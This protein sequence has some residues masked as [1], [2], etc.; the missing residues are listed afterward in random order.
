MPQTENEPR[1]RPVLVWAIFAV[2]CVLLLAGI[3]Y[4]LAIFGLVTADP[5]TAEKLP[6][7]RWTQHVAT[8]L[9]TT[10]CFLGAYRLFARRGGAMGLYIAGIA[11]YVFSNLVTYARGC[12]YYGCPSLEF[13]RGML[14]NLLCFVVAIFFIW[15]A[16]KS[17]P[18][19][20]LL[21]NK[22]A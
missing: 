16:L 3:W 21:P 1:R 22:N 4:A 10:R 2:H 9:A 8:L 7:L 12:I 20:A 19:N 17:W 14:F 15:V 13:F 11:V 18:P 5:E 6:G